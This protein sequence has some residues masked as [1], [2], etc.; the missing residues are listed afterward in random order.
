MWVGPAIEWSFMW[1]ENSL[2]CV[3]EEIAI[4]RKRF[5]PT[6][7]SHRSF[8]LAELNKACRCDADDHSYEKREPCELP[9][10]WRIL[11]CRSERPIT[12]SVSFRPAFHFQPE[13]PF[14]LIRERVHTSAKRPVSSPRPSRDERKETQT[15]IHVLRT[16]VILNQAQPGNLTVTTLH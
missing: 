2:P 3:L 10:L 13:T 5:R 12:Q 6:A 4:R 14:C 1:Y 15:I 11:F 7:A 9:V 16:S 8:F